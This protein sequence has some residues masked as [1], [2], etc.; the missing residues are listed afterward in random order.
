MR[1]ET[2]SAFIVLKI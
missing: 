2:E 1:H